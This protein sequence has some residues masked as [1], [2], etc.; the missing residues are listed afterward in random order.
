[1][2]GRP[3]GLLVAEGLSLLVLLTILGTLGVSLGSA[4]NDGLRS[5]LAKK[6]VDAAPSWS[7]DGSLIAFVRTA[8]GEGT[9]YVMD[10]DGAEQIGLTATSPGTG[11]SWLGRT[12]IAFLRSERA[13]SSTVDGA[14]VR[15]LAR[16][17]PALSHPA[18]RALSPNGRH[19]AFVRDG[20]I[21]VGG[22][23][24]QQAVQL[25]GT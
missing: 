11:L 1:M 22:R 7:P 10:A 19:L 21:F 6:P 25:T 14:F 3:L 9:L 12:R 8:H 17:P 15:P 20:H 13:F 5:S 18:A 2:R 23:H 16:T 4:V 24:G